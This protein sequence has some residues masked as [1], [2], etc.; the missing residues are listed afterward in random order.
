MSLLGAVSCPRRRA[1]SSVRGGSGVR[2]ACQP[3]CRNRPISSR[4]Q[5]ARPLPRQTRRRLSVVTPHCTRRPGSRRLLRCR[6][7]RAA[8]H[9]RAHPARPCPPLLQRYARARACPVR[10]GA[11]MEPRKRSSMITRHAVQVGVPA[12]LSRLSASRT[13]EVRHVTWGA[14]GR[15]VPCSHSARLGPAARWITCRAAWMR[16][17]GRT[18][19]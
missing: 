4:T 1:D 7:G 10:G 8:G 9:H 18:S 17:G 13:S 3:P 5:S 6:R 15:R 12:D 19:S 11:G 14:R 2:I 16:C